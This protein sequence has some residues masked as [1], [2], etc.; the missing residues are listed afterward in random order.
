VDAQENLRIGNTLAR[1]LY[2]SYIAWADTA[3]LTEEEETAKSAQLLNNQE[4]L[5][6]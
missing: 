3:D 5:S 4:E 2:E 1:N 6:I